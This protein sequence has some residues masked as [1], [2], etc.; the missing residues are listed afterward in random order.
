MIA[1]VGSRYFVNKDY[2][3]ECL[4][5]IV[6]EWDIEIIKIITGGAR[7]ADSLAMDYAK[8]NNIELEVFFA[9]WEKFGRSAGPIRNT[10]IID[11]CKYFVAFLSP[12]SKGTRDSIKKAKQSNKIIKIFDI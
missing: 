8:E 2:F 6:L 11:S 5:K 9:D 1:I 10:K 4:N 3:L 7:G 12:D